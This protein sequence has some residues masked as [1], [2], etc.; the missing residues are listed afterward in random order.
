MAKV[1][2]KREAALKKLNAAIAKFLRGEITREALD[3]ALDKY[4]AIKPAHKR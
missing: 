2:T 1:P 4:Q 3:D